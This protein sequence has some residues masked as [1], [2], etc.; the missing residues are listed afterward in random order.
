MLD[1]QYIPIFE[2][3]NFNFN[4]KST[5]MSKYNTHKHAN[6]QLTCCQFCVKLSILRK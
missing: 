2:E 6:T 5:R 3:F 1:K 4:Y